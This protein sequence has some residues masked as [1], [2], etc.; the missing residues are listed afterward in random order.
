MNVPN[1][2]ICRNNLFCAT[3]KEFARLYCEKNTFRH[4]KKLLHRRCPEYFQT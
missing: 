4:D 2:L 3:G 1:Q